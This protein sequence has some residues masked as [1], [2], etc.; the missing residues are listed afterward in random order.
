MAVGL[1][2]ADSPL[3]AALAARLEAGGARVVPLDETA[4]PALSAVVHLPVQAGPAVRAA[5]DALLAAVAEGR[6]PLLVVVTG[7]EV[8]DAPPGCPVPL[9]EG[10]P[11][12]AVEPGVPLA[13]LLEL[14]RQVE[15]ARPASGRAG[16]GRIVV[17]RPAALLGPGAV[18]ALAGQLAGPRLLGVRG[19]APRWQVCHVDDLAS[20]LAMVLSAEPAALPAAAA[21]ASAG[22]LDADELQAASGLRRVELSPAVAAAGAARLR[23]A[24]AAAGIPAGD[25]LPLSEDPPV[26]ATRRLAALGWSP[27]WEAAA[28]VRDHLEV[29]R[30]PRRSGA[31][32][33]ATMAG[34]TV[35]L[36]GTAAF[37][38]RVRRRRPQ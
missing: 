10:S 13:D 21:V 17:L 19:G 4:P 12:R 28:A 30:Q 29:A 8:Y 37:V 14:E 6:L 33:P 3:G 23:R 15:A 2:G 24:R 22:C 32:A 1:T 5:T 34:A 36:I 9:P 35:A 31:A 16:A 18:G 11:L 27:R 20:A 26:L 25:G 38:R 7:T